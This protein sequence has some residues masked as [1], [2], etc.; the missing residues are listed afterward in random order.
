MQGLLAIKVGVRDARFGDMGFVGCDQ[1]Q[2]HVCAKVVRLALLLE[3]AHAAGAPQLSVVLDMW[4][5]GSQSLLH[6]GL[7]GYQGGSVLGVWSAVGCRL[8]A[9]D[10]PCAQV[11]A[12]ALLVALPLDLLDMADAAGGLQLSVVLDMRQ[13][14]SQSLLH[15][16]LA[17]YQG[18]W[19]GGV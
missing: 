15:A 6:A 16:G 12:Q 8:C 3:V 11:F 7:A 10:A 19:M 18:G 14:G 17:G 2:L 13:H 1:G 4:L 5:H 9:S